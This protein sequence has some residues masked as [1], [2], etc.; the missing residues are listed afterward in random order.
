MHSGAI[1]R[2]R[3]QDRNCLMSTTPICE[4]VTLPYDVL[5][6]DLLAE[7]EALDDDS[8]PLDSFCG[9]ARSGKIS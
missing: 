3:A 8:M 4:Q 6:D 1:N 7:I 9:L 2:P 5:V